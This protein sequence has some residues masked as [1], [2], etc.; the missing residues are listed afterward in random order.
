MAEDVSDLSRRA[1]DHRPR[2]ATSRVREKFF[3]F[4]KFGS[5]VSR[6]ARQLHWRGNVEE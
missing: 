3:P 4:R 6:D 2:L 5:I 1:R